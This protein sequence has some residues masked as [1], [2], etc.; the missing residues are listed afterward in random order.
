LIAAYHCRDNFRERMMKIYFCGSIAGGRK[1]EDVYGKIVDYLKAQAHQVLSEHI[2]RKDI[3]EY[4]RQFTPQ[5]IFQRDIEMLNQADRV[6]A[7]ISNPS[8]GVG[9]EICHALQRN[10]KVLCVYQNGLYVS[11]M[12]TGNT[13]PGIR[14]SSYRKFDDLIKIVDRF[15]TDDELLET[16][17]I[18]PDVESG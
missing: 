15:V 13:M 16:D 8:L 3:F 6:I 11:R 4:E 7:E 2:V 9:Y 17:E 1:F 10:M 14:I 12:I 5:Q 18:K